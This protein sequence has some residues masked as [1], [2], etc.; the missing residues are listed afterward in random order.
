MNTYEKPGEGA[1]LLV[2]TTHIPDRTERE[3]AGRGK[4]FGTCVQNGVSWGT[5]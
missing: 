5:T 4:N 2:T 1:A 3:W